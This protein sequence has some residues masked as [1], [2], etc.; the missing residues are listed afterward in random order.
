MRAILT[1][2]LVALLGLPALAGE[3]ETLRLRIQGMTC[4]RC[5][6]SAKRVLESHPA[7][8]NATVNLKAGEATVVLRKPVSWKALHQH[9]YQELGFEARPWGAPPDPALKPLPESV[10]SSLDIRTISHGEA[11]DLKEHLARGKVTVVEFYADW[12]T[13]CHLLSPR[14]EH[15]IH[16]LP[17]VALRVVDISDWETPAARQATQE[18]AMPGLPYVRVYAP[19]GKFLGEVYGN[20]FDE[21]QTLV[22]PH[23]PEQQ[24]EEE[25]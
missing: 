2:L 14:L 24:H 9:L 22:K 19:D 15:M 11:V 17:G 8:E 5:Q 18:Y 4:S 10:R 7:V 1:T 23:L 12:C 13:P 3:T 6:A 16:D 20:R 21:V 25:E